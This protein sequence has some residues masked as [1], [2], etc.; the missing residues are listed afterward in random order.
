MLLDILCCI[1]FLFIIYKFIQWIFK[2]GNGFSVGGEE[3]TSSLAVS[4]GQ[5]VAIYTVYGYIVVYFDYFLVQC[6]GT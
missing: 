1:L 6:V 4:I 5:K 2:W 3:K